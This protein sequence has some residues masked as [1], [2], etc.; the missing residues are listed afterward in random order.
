VALLLSGTLKVGL[1]T[2]AYAQLTLPIPG[3]DAFQE[4]LYRLVPFDPTK[5]EEGVTAQGTLLIGL[6]GLIGLASWKGI[7]RIHEGFNR[8]TWISLIL[9]GLTLLTAALGMQ[10]H[11]GGLDILFTGKFFGVLLALALLGWL[12]RKQLNEDEQRDFLWESWKF[13]KQIF[14]LLIVG[15][16]S[17]GVIRVLIRPEW[18][19]ALAGDN[20]LLGNL[21]GVVFGVFMYFPTLVEVPIANMFLSLGM[22]RGPLL[23]YLMADHELSL[24]SILITATIIG[25]STLAGLI[26]GSWVDGASIGLIALYLAAFVAILTGGLWW[27]SRRN[28]AHMNAAQ[29]VSK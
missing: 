3:L 15:V 28:Q 19:E 23:A 16:F 18:I 9:V 27:V 1:L 12:L 2:N 10:P 21:A 20:T 6:L 25:F 14:P 8:W 5:G 17:V 29:E 7:E 24:Q 13:V 11:A 22:H 26:Y 4:W